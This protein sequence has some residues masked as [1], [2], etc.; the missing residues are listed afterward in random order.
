MNFDGFL[1]GCKKKKY[2]HET[3]VK[4]NWLNPLHSHD[5]CL[6]VC[7]YEQQQQLPQQNKKK[8]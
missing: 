2:N 5:K 7:M 4:K 3:I 1:Y 6:N 8:N